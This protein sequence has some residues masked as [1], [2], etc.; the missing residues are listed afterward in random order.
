[1]PAI[2]GQQIN[3][4]IDTVH[5]CQSAPAS[6][7]AGLTTRLATALLSFTAAIALFSRQYV[8]RS[9]SAICFSPSE[10]CRS[11]S[12]SFLSRSINSCRKR[13]FS[14]LR[15]SFS[16]SSCP[17]SLC[18]VGAEDERCWR[19]ETLKHPHCQVFQ[20]RSRSK[21]NFLQGFFIRTFGD[22][23]NCYSGCHFGDQPGDVRYSAQFAGSAR[24]WIPSGSKRR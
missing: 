21:V 14:R 4:L 23:L 24:Q 1:M 16:R 11:A 10:I 9:R 2:G 7:M 17:R 19:F 8:R 18:G 5:R 22:H 20:Q 15:R 13:S 6:G 12:A 3:H